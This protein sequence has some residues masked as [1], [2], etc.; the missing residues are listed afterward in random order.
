MS[1]PILYVLS[2]APGSGKS[3]CMKFLSNRSISIIK[4]L[5]TRESRITDSIEISSVKNISE[6]CDIRYIQYGVEY[7]FASSEIWNSFSNGLDVAVIVNDIRTIRLLKQRFGSLVRSIYIHRN[8]SKADL[9]KLTKA[10]HSTFSKTIEDDLKRREKKIET[11]HQKYIENTSLFDFALLNLSTIEDLL[12][13]LGNII[14]HRD[15]LQKNLKSHVNIF[16]IVGASY[17]GKDD[18]VTAMVQMD[19]DRVV[20][21]RKATTRPRR[22][23]DNDELRH[24][25]IIDESFNLIYEKNGFRYAISSNELWDSLSQGTMNLLVLSDRKCIEL[26]LEE[27]GHICKVIYLHANLDLS[28]MR[29]LMENEGINDAETK[30]RLDDVENLYHFYV[31][32]TCMF[33]HVLINTAERE[34]LYD[35]AFNILDNYVASK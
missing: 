33:N 14:D 5:T 26:L 23:G 35:Q 7:G 12:S 2:G 27:F 31:E 17:S 34:D 15:V 30:E 25:D 3:E 6:Y 20:N 24:G 21:Y 13:Q 8:L 9:A 22:T 1:N 4:K 10:R 18:L 11:I 32:K 19:R 28:Q 16:I 29:Y